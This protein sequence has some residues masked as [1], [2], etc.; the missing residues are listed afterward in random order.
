[1]LEPVLRSLLVPFQVVH[2]F[3]STTHIETTVAELKEDQSGRRLI[4]IYVGDHDAAGLRMSED[5]LP[6]RLTKHGAFNFEIRRVALTRDDFELKDYQQPA[7]ENDVNRE[8]Y[9][10][11]TGLTRGVELEALSSV[12]LRDRLDAAIRECVTDATSWNRVMNTNKA[13]RES[14]QNY[15]AQWEPPIQGLVPGYG[16]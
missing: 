10:R 13:I 1:M 7:K 5:D 6:S 15:A 2:G 11:H 9:Q 12:V 14:W 8:W 4:V 16:E 3:T